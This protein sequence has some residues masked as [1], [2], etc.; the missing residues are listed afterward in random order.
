MRRTDWPG[1]R[2]PGRLIAVCVG[3]SEALEGGKMMTGN[4]R[5]DGSLRQAR[6]WWN[7]AVRCD[8]MGDAGRRDEALIRAAN[9]YDRARMVGCAA[10]CRAWVGR[11][12][13]KWHGT[14]FV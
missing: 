10:D 4:T 6:D 13:S 2:P 8:E 14:R 11:S 9:A 1:V 12:L 3:R 7:A 5:L